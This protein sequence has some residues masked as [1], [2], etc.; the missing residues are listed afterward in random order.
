MAW[1][2]VHVLL[3]WKLFCCVSGRIRNTNCTG[4]RFFTLKFSA[5]AYSARDRPSDRGDVAPSSIRLLL[6][7]LQLIRTL[8][9]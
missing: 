8:I 7:V 4:L 6:V 3:G 1:D 2:G 9:V 5:S